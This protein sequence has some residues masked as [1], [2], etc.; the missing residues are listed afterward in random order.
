MNMR[1]ILAGRDAVAVDTIE[2]LIMGWD[3]MSVK[4][5]RY[6][7]HD[8]LGNLDPACINVVGRRVDE[9][10]KFFAGVTPRAGGERIADTLPPGLAVAGFSVAGEHL[11]LWLEVAT[12]AVK[13]ELELDGWLWG[14]ALTTG[15][16]RVTLDL[17]GLAPGRHTLSINA[18]DRFLNRAEEIL[19]VTKE[20]DGS[21]RIEPVPDNSYRAP[22]AGSAPVIDGKGTDKCWADAPWRGIEYL[23]L[24][25]EPS[26][27]DFS[28]RYKVVWTPE[29][30]YL[31]VEITDDKLSDTHPDGLVDYYKDDCLEIFLDENRSG[32]DHTYNYNAFAYHIAIDGKVADLG[33]DRR[34]LYFTDHIRIKRTKV[35][36]VY[37]WE[38]AIDVYDDRYDDKFTG[39][40]P[41][42]LHAGKRMGLAVAYCDNDGGPD[43][44]SFVGS[45]EIQG[46][47]KNVAWQNADVFG[48][49]ILEE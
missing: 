30:L 9:V 25:E 22:R 38:I 15:F 35:G 48:G 16:E 49:L 47:D 29:K 27:A 32:G 42:V 10:R 2:A 7:N 5:L 26:P 24:G 39:N 12:E 21:L 8:G 33:P 18:Y 46:A 14:P 45:E 37:T 23:W 4:H 13:L 41:I 40:K 11:T 17:G 31:L 20:A 3:P 34:P 44:E 19:T 43:R 1:L 28:G 6:L 36:N